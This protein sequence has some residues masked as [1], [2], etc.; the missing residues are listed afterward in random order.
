MNFGDG[1]RRSVDAPAV[2]WTRRLHVRLAALFA[3]LF[4]V[5]GVVV[6]KLRDELREMLETRA[7]TA[8]GAS[9]SAIDTVDT[10]FIF[11]CLAATAGIAGLVTS[12][13]VT[14]R[15]RKMVETLREPIEFGPP[16]P[17]EPLAAY[18]DEANRDDEIGQLARAINGMHARIT[19]L[20]G[21]LE[22]RERDRREWLSRI[23]H[24][25]RTPLT[26]LIACISRARTAVREY[27]E[28]DRRARLEDALRVAQ[29]DAD[30]FHALSCDL[31]DVARLERENGGGVREPVPPIELVRS[32]ATSLAVLAEDLGMSIEIDAPRMLPELEADGHRLARA[33][34]NLVRNA[35]QH[36]DSEVVMSVECTGDAIQFAV[37]DDGE[38]LPVDE[39]GD[40]NFDEL[41]LSPGRREGTGIGLL[42]ARDVAEVHGGEIG[43]TNRKGGGALVWMRIPLPAGIRHA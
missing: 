29:V 36:G 6:P 43:G 1:R 8:R 11:L 37:C 21:S 23:S 4:L 16:A 34:E 24:D 41:A 3:A 9:E 20:V 30:R 38:G 22:E 14:R 12:H 39:H 19:E 15:L 18:V 25:L 33:L 10:A 27:P 40:V 28:D 5:A 17:M 13:L 31:L 2:P 26:A 32:V 42:V 35:L 7:G